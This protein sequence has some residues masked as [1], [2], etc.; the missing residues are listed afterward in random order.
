MS[1]IAPLV[2]FLEWAMNNG[3]WSGDDLDGADVQN[4]AIELGLIVET[5]YDPQ[6]HG[7]NGKSEYAEP[8]DQWF[9]FA[10]WLKISSGDQP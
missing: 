8:G 2:E 1:K 5:K 6:I 9:V 7:R 4:K 3:P 10:D